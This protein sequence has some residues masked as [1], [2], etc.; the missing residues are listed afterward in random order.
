MPFRLSDLS[1]RPL[2]A[3]PFPKQARQFRS[4]PPEQWSGTMMD[5]GGHS[6]P[7]KSLR[8]CLQSSGRP[9]RRQSIFLHEP[10]RLSSSIAN[11]IERTPSENCE[12]GR[13]MTVQERARSPRTTALESPPSG[14]ILDRHLFRVL[15]CN[16]GKTPMHA[17]RSRDCTDMLV[18]KKRS[19]SISRKKAI[20]SPSIAP[21]SGKSAA[22]SRAFL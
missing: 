17:N 12:N 20:P 1:K 10:A 14:A 4:T 19:A 22:V 5:F 2:Q 11:L 21:A 15:T 8:R 3:T 7:T 6:L 13:S 18:K 16:L 9:P